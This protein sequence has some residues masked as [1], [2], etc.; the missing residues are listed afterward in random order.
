MTVAERD[1]AIE[2]FVATYSKQ[3]KDDPVLESAFARWQA[4]AMG[5]SET[6]IQWLSGKVDTQSFTKH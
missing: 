6:E 3:I 4:H 5:I 2:K 1:A